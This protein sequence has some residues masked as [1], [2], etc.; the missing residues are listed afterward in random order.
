MVFLYQILY[1]NCHVRNSDLRIITKL[2]NDARCG[3]DLVY[4][5]VNK[6]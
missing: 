1:K 5:N 4:L 3:D 2:Y 6:T